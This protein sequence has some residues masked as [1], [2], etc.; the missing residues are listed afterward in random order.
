S[1]RRLLLLLAAGGQLGVVVLWLVTRTA[2]L[3]FGPDAGVAE[4][5]GLGDVLT[6]VF[7]LVAFLAVIVPM[8][9][10]FATLRVPREAATAATAVLVA[11][12]A[13]TTTL[14]FAPTYAHGAGDSHSHSDAAGGSGGHGHGGAGDE[15]D[16]ETAAAHG[17]A[18]GEAGS[19]IVG[20]GCRHLHGHD[21]GAATGAGGSGEGASGEGADAAPVAD[22][23]GLPPVTPQQQAAADKLVQ[24][25]IASTNKW[26]TLEA[27]YAAGYYPTNI[28]GPIYHLGNLE[29][30]RSPQT[31]DPERPEALVYFKLG[32]RS[33]L[34]GTMY[35]M[36]E[37]GEPGPLV[38]GSLTSWHVHTNL[39][40]DPVKYTTMNP[41]PDGSC[42][43]GA[44]IGPTPE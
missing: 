7:E 9:P 8:L 13:A 26:P 28:S 32:D 39:Y 18:E 36:T 19:G 22:N 11:A 23:G 41:N 31:L 21:D 25:T 15:A 27:A 24:D 30:R 4:A 38:G 6:V 20:V 35:T 37:I 40:F 29:Y 2:G 33:M 12:I 16:A 42:E 44:A 34:V 1:E 43:P 3:P 14:S 17:H 5:A 10:N